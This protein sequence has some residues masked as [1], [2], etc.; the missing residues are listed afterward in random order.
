MLA[1]VDLQRHVGDCSNTVRKGGN[2]RLGWLGRQR[3]KGPLRLQA[4]AAAPRSQATKAAQADHSSAPSSAPAVRCHSLQPQVTVFIASASIVRASPKSDTCEGQRT[5]KRLVGAP[6][7]RC[8]EAG[9]GGGGHGRQEGISNQAANAAQLRGTHFGAEG[10]WVSRR[11]RPPQQQHV[12]GGQVAVDDVLGVQVGEGLS[13]FLQRQVCRC[14]SLLPVRTLWV[15]FE[16]GAKSWP[17][18]HTQAA[19]PHTARLHRTGAGFPRPAH[20]PLPA[21]LPVQSA[22]RRAG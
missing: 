13:N 21:S 8:N 5:S 22:A 9:S 3:T 14:D 20:L 7:W 10:A 2:S 17:P 16:A 11:G 1:L 15:M 18:C 12:V 19:M 4:Q 6:V